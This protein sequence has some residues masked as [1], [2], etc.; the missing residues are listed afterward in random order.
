MILGIFLR[1][2][3][4]KVIPRAHHIFSHINFTVGVMS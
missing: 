3:K 1:K 4:N 2:A